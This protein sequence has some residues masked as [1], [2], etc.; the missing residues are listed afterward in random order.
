MAS[1]GIGSANH[2]FGASFA[3]MA[4][5]DLVHVP[6]RGSATAEIAQ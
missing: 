5:I 6:Y 4:G 1:P 2:I 3:M